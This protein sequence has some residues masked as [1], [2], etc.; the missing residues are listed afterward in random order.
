MQIVLLLEE[1]ENLV[2]ESFICLLLLANI[3]FFVG[4]MILDLFDVRIL[5]VDIGLE[6]GFVLGKVGSLHHRV[7]LDHSVLEFFVETIVDLFETHNMFVVVWKGD[8][9]TDHYS[10][11]ISKKLHSKAVP[12]EVPSLMVCG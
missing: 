6:I 9:L 1:S 7:F 2:F 12:V 3:V 4:D 11:L 8:A 5:V 10:Q